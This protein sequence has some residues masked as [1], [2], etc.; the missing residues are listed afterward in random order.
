MI[1]IVIIQHCV[2]VGVI[3]LLMHVIM[4]YF[5]GGVKK[6]TVHLTMLTY[7]LLNMTVP[8]CVDIQLMMLVLIPNP[9]NITVRFY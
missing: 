6:H 7:K 8:A 3:L 9:S 2:H 4:W 1:V 5:Q